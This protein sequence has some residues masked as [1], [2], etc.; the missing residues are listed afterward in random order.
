MR[1]KDKIS[2]LALA[3]LFLPFTSVQAGEDD[4]GVWTEVGMSKALPHNLEVSLD[5]ELRTQDN[6][7]M[8]DRLGV[9][10]N[11]SYKPTKF[12]KFQAGYA[13]LYSYHPEEVKSKYKNDQEEDFFLENRKITEKYWTPRH[14]I[15][16]DV[17]LDHK[18]W[19]CIKLSLRERYQ[20]T[21]RAEQ[22][23]PRTKIEYYYNNGLEEKPGG[24]TY[25]Y[26][27][28]KEKQ[29]HMLR[30]RLEVEYDKKKCDWKPFVSYEFYNDLTDK[31]K[32]T[33]YKLILGTSYKL[34][35]KH[36]L[37]LSYLYNKE[38]EEQPNE[39]RHALILGF[40]YKF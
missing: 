5:A 8:M 40:G 21:Y 11:L 6:A 18:F 34:T 22:E 39:G 17:V 14:R 24:R 36:Q 4:F 37:K 29:T 30:S 7:G 32:W 13:F 25:D 31:M 26:D 12:L 38:M 20:Y 33:E 10:A 3:A 15:K 28:K 9:G 16:L 35:K 23:I 1:K 2:I 27:R 19:K